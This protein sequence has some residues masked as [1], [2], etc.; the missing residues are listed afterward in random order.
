MIL[1]E[2]EEDYVTT[3]EEEDDE[4]EPAA[5]LASMEGSEGIGSA[6]GDLR[7]TGSLERYS[8][9]SSSGESAVTRWGRWLSARPELQDMQERSLNIHRSIHAEQN[10]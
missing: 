1:E 8:T 2:A 10:Y 7:S 9:L 4:A 5:S 3:S 6:E